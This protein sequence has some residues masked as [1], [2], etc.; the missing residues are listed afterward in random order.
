MYQKDW[1]LNAYFFL[2]IHQVSILR[3]KNIILLQMEHFA[4]LNLGVSY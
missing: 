4:L 2:G 1:F 3:K